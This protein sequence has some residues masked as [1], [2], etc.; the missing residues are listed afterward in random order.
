MIGDDSDIEFLP[1]IVDSAITDDSD[2]GVYFV[3][4]TLT[5]SGRYT[6][7]ILLRALE[8]P[9][10]LTSI[11]V[12]PALNTIATT[13]NFTG[14]MEPYHT[15]EKIKITIWGRDVFENLRTVSVADAF[16]LTVTGLYTG[17]YYGTHMAVS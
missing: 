4:A 15:G 14:V 9:T 8:V 1:L 12:L 2:A 17:T 7:Q 3:S 11:E 10:G 6:L 13:S 16:T 5:K